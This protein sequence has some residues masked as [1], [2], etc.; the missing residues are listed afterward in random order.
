MALSDFFIVLETH[1]EIRVSRELHKLVNR[2]LECSGRLIEDVMQ[3]DNILSGDSCGIS[4]KGKLVS[5]NLDIV[6]V[7]GGIGGL[8]AAACLLKRGH[9]VRVFEQAAELTEI[10][11]GIQTSA[12]A[13]VVLHD[14]GLQSRLAAQSN[15]PETW[16]TR[17]HDSGEVIKE[18]PLGN[19]H[20]SLHGVPYYLLHRADFHQMLVDK[21]RELDTDAIHL[22]A[23]AQRFV[24]ST[25]S[26][27]VYFSNEESV[28][29]DVLIAADGIR[30]AMRTQIIGN[31]KPTY[32]GNAA[33]RA[34]VPAEKLP[35]NF[36][37]NVNTTWVGPRKHAM[38]Y[39]LRGGTLFNFV[40]AVETEAWTS[41]SWTERF[42]WEHMK[43]DFDGWHP[44]IQ[45]IVDACDKHGCYR[46]ALNSREPVD[47][48]RTRRAILI[49]DAAH[50]TLPF[51]AQGAS[52]A[53]EDAAVLARAL[54]YD[55]SI[56]DR[57]ELF[58][59]NRLERTAKITR[60]AVEMGRKN[61]LD[62]ADEI[63]ESYQTDSELISTRDEWLFSYNP[64]TIP[65]H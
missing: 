34:I 16:Y 39:W 56:E 44:K 12:N 3:G 31:D 5:A 59:R 55:A 23:T 18:I 20:E 28:T 26:V 1:C 9:Q 40:A 33:W 45:T 53:I 63:I 46:W 10:G 42:P 50:P 25:D 11:A 36:I 62:T 29:A 7:G 41:E 35:N 47:N 51:M 27:T 64:L 49:G 15:S 65:L 30:S 61:H 13:G 14:L 60:G 4:V 43:A 37:G 24:E 19:R 8:T 32:T 21:V 38:T 2:A 54:D 58:Q 17:L 52:M 57:L 6:I 22:G 48:W